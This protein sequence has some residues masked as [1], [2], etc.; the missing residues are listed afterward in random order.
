M[1]NVPGCSDSELGRK[2]L[3]AVGAA[4]AADW[5]SSSNPLSVR[6]ASGWLD[7]GCTVIEGRGGREALVVV[8]VEK[9]EE[10]E[11]T[12]NV[13]VGIQAELEL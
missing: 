6:S 9:L 11:A 3:P 13:E 10:E 7:G 1:L 2:N 4:A 8:V 5:S 12:V